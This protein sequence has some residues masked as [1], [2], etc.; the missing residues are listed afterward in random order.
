MIFLNLSAILKGE[1]FFSERVI[2]ATGGKAA[3]QFGTDGQGY[4]LATSF[5]HR[6]TSLYPSL[7]QLKTEKVKISGLKGIKENASVTLCD[8]D[9]PIK[10]A[11]G[12]VLFTDYGVS[13]NVFIGSQLHLSSDTLCAGF[14]GTVFS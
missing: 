4:S 10:Q 11:T 8:G 2:L 12:D 7:V 1:K 14:F 9:R 6:L 3:K 13:G 5:G